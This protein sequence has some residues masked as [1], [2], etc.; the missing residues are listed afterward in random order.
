MFNYDKNSPQEALYREVPT[1][2]ALG[3]RFFRVYQAEGV[4]KAEDAEGRQLVLGLPQG[5]PDSSIMP[6]GMYD[7]SRLKSVFPG[8]LNSLEEEARRSFARGKRIIS[9]AEGNLALLAKQREIDKSSKEKFQTTHP[10]IKLSPVPDAVGHRPFTPKH[11]KDPS[12]EYWK[13]D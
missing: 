5:L 8:D 13:H 11:Q 10:I 2:I 3:P 9:I 7:F 6:E 1:D 4:W 12:F